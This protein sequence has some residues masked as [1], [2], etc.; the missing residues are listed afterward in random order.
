[1]SDDND[2]DDAP[3]KTKRKGKG[4]PQFPSASSMAK[5]H[6]VKPRS[7]ESGE[8]RMM[9]YMMQRNGHGSL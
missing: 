7:K 3:V 8:V 1:M 5:K 4:K 2:A 9:G 6:R